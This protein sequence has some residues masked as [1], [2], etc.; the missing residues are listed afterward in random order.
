MS[1]SKKLVTAIMAITLVT[2]SSCLSYAKDYKDT[3]EHWANSSIQR[4]SESEVVRGYDDGSFK[5]NNSMTRAE[6]AQVINNV[7]KL[8]KSGKL[9]FSDVNEKDWFTNAILTCAEAGIVN[10]KDDGTFD[11]NDPITRE[12]A[13]TMLGRALDFEA[14]S[15][16]S[17]SIYKDYDEVSDYAKGYFSKMVEEK[18][19]NGVTND[20]LAPKKVATRAE[21]LTML[22]RAIGKYID[23][24]GEYEIEE[25]DGR[26]LVV[27]KD[28]KLSGV[29]DSEV[30][31]AQGADEGKVEL[32]NAEVSSDII[33][34]ADDSTILVDEESSVK[35]IEIEASGVKAEVSGNVENIDVTEKAADTEISG[36]GKVSEVNVLEG[37]ENTNIKTHE[38]KV[39]TEEGSKG[40]IADDKEVK[41]GESVT[42]EKKETSGGSH[43]GETPEIKNYKVTFEVT[44]GEYTGEREVSVKENEKVT[45]QVAPTREGYYFDGW[46]LND[47]KYDFETEV[48]E[49]ITLKAVWKYEIKDME[50][51][52]HFV[53]TAEIEEEGIITAEISVNEMITINREVVIDGNNQTLKA[54]DELSTYSLIKFM[55][56][57]TLKNL[58]ID[59]ENKN[60]RG[61]Y[62][63]GINGL[64]ECELINVTIKNANI[65]NPG[66]A[67]ATKNEVNLTLDKCELS[68]NT[69]KNGKD[70]TL[71]FGKT[72]GTLTLIDTVIT[73]NTA[74]KN[75]AG[76]WIGSEANLVVKGNTIIKDNN[77]DDSSSCTVN[78]KADIFINANASGAGENKGGNAIIES[79]EIGNIHVETDTDCYA[80]LK[81]KG[82][83][84]ENAHGNGEKSELVME[85]E[86]AMEINGE[87]LD[88]GTYKWNME[89]SKWTK[90]EE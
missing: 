86:V 12:Q 17:L 56:N 20:S 59:L 24:D 37:A 16:K 84:I 68:N 36:N 77:C 19:I 45:E 27:A 76:V 70:A 10:G 55:A 9:K 49:D 67:I 4:W 50:T 78:G 48:K 53:E 58:N 8:K 79:G 85:L 81:V 66:S 28:V 71:H 75:T 44:E 26:V 64:I 39:K 63:D 29:I 14:G 6:Y 47:E 23:K 5:P 52:K 89:S 65:E 2:M 15:S 43:G 7:L 72:K 18:I 83:K 35:N 3:N 41:A 62:F 73:G 87:E 69:A 32:E 31:V 46:Y 1:K 90:Q 60:K 30:I 33:I 61:L 57:G 25:N 88:A 74:D 42:T 54:N 80:I 51:F 11:P 82:G 40:T 22:N 34:L 38:T 13:V 21:V